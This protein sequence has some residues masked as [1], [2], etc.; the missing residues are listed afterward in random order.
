MI[1]F[2]DGRAAHTIIEEEKIAMAEQFEAR[3]EQF[4]ADPGIRAELEAD[5][6]RIVAV[7]SVA[8]TAEGAYPYGEA[9]ARALDAALEMGRRMG[10]RT[11][12]HG[13]RC[14][15]IL[16]GNGATERGVVCHLDVVPASDAG[17]SAPPF[18][19]T[20]RDGL[21]IGRGAIDDKGPFIQALYT[22]RFLKECGAALP[23]TI[24]LLLGSDEEAGSSDLTYFASV[25]EPPAFSF[26]PDAEFPVCVGEKGILSVNIDL[27]KL[28]PLFHALAG[29]SASNAVPEH[30]EAVIR[31]EP[32]ALPRRDGIAVEAGENGYARVVAAGK[33]AHAAEPEPGMNAIALLAGYLLE[34]VPALPAA[35]AALLHFV[36][37]AGSDNYGGLFGIAARNERFGPLT[38]VASMLSVQEGRVV[39]HCNIRYLPH[40]RADEVLADIRRALPDF[41]V[42]RV[43]SSEGYDAGA[44]DPRVRA[45]TEAAEAVLNAACPPY[46]MGGGT[47]ARWLP[48]TVAFGPA[49]GRERGRLGP[50]KGGPHQIDEY[51]SERELFDGI[52]IY[53]R[54]FL[55]LAALL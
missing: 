7:E 33:P 9:C 21:Y 32:G 53:G 50:G 2:T 42:E 36:C 24:R 6:A 30:A 40:R 38:C 52:R 8:G 20:K 37:E 11:E 29:G 43:D 19:L 22:L 17:W 45:L 18:A 23:F 39:L 49:I 44:D 51:I 28:P 13:Y 5:F 47:Y 12:N 14:A 41:A 3:L 31:M 54:A 27:G 16:Y 1:R 15:S 4:L 25:C 55:N 46:T 34:C 10:F 35:E 26:T 48:N